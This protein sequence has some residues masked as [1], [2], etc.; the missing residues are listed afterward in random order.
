M[1][2]RFT[3]ADDGFAVGA[4][5]FHRPSSCPYWVSPIEPDGRR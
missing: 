2:T 1:D 3:P 5:A 4:T